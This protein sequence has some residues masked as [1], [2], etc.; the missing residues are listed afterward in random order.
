MLGIP[1]GDWPLGCWTVVVRA[2]REMES[3]W[4]RAAT[5]TDL[6]RTPTASSV[7]ALA[8]APNWTFL[9]VDTPGTHI[10][11][12]STTNGPIAVWCTQHSVRCSLLSLRMRPRA[13]KAGEAADVMI[14]SIDFGAAT[15]NASLPVDAV[16][17]ELQVT[18]LTVPAP[19]FGD[20]SAAN[21]T[22]HH[23]ISVALSSGAIELFL[24][25]PSVPQIL[26]ITSVSPCRSPGSAAHDCPAFPHR[27]G[28]DLQ[29]RCALLCSPRPGLLLCYD[30]TATLTSVPAK[31]PS[32]PSPTVIG[33]TELVDASIFIGEPQKSTQGMT[34]PMVQQSSSLSAI[35]ITASDF[36]GPLNVLGVAS[37]GT[38]LPAAEATTTGIDA[39]V[40]DHDVFI[41]ATSDA[42]GR[43]WSSTSVSKAFVAA[44]KRASTGE[45]FFSTIRFCRPSSSVLVSSAGPAVLLCSDSSPSNAVPRPW[46]E[47][48][49]FSV[50]VS[51][52]AATVE[53]VERTEF[54]V[55]CAIVGNAICANALALR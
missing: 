51:D 1:A 5:A 39:A 22:N 6:A 55:V 27:I 48:G 44:H 38:A 7:P 8:S 3:P 47:V 28:I 45:K 18:P 15:V 40:G 12:V 29:R 46:R 11:V 42:I 16:P 17:T 10:N 52:V 4:T 53:V 13:T 25:D 31:S 2:F 35:S 50:T 30:L 32:R 26:S 23:V 54:V 43:T 34:F 24:L 37:R 41:V 36:H 20:G 33:S 19:L 9:H 14:T 49:T 21:H